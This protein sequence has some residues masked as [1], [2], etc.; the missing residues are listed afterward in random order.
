MLCSVLP[1]ERGNGTISLAKLAKVSTMTQ[2]N[3][4]EAK[5]NLSKLAK[6]LEDGIEDCIIVARNGKPLLRITLEKE[7]DTSRRFG[8][9]KG[10]FTFPEDIDDIDISEDFEGRVL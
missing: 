2:V 8:I 5:T 9:G 10:L 7:V 1:M 6:M 3:M 4:F